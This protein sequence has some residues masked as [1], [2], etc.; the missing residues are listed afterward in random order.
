MS[1]TINIVWF[2]RDLRLRDH[3]PLKLAC[4][5]KLPVHLIYTI[6]PSM[7]ADPHLDPRHWRFI[8]E[9]LDTLNHQLNRFGTRVHIYWGEALPIL[10]WLHTQ[11]RVHTLYSHEET[12]IRTSFERDKSI[13]KWC[14]DAGIAWQ[15]S[16]SN[17]VQRGLVNRKRWDEDWLAVMHAQQ[18][19]ANLAA[20]RFVNRD[21][22][23][24][25]V[26]SKWKHRNQ[27][28]QA[29]GEL[30]AQQCL[31]SFLAE[32]GRRYAEDIAKP[33]ASRDSCSRL[34]PYLAWGNL[35]LRDVVQRLASQRA[36]YGWGRSL[37]AFRSRLHWHC[38][39]IQKF[40]SQCSME[41]EPVNPGYSDFPYRT[42]E[43]SER[44]LEAWQNGETGV[45]LIDACMRCL[46]TTGYI[47][48]RMRAMLVSFLCHHLMIDW[49]RGAHHLARMFLDFEPG[50]H[51]PQLQMQAGVT[52]INTI[53]VYNP[54]KQ[55]K[56][57]DAEGHFVR[58]WCPELKTLPTELIFEP[59]T[60]TPME[61]A[62]LGSSII[63]PIVDVQA[64]A[65]EARS[66]LWSWRDRAEVKAW[67]SDILGRHVRP[68]NQCKQP[69]THATS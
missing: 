1:E 68:D 55:A 51:Y 25:Q 13:A 12:G 66:L 38:H 63:T 48:F 2:K 67:Q 20:A 23:A 45:P 42:G 40:E 34:S 28:M 35:S 64:A 19:T 10:C 11:H 44:D 15:L 62:M 52:G 69:S 41:F 37:R 9:S 22:H 30:A 29:G 32:R 54:I 59:W 57:H 7:V 58:R 16:A 61:Q 21:D 5:A 26:P 39:F 46:H 49:R 24:A 18:A 14:A 65:R 47:N 8:W 3:E 17:A 31:E 53:R 33:G 50:I 56:E 6:E 36:P 60:T 43:R 4:A 27:H